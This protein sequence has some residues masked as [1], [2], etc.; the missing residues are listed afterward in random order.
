MK[1]IQNELK[2]VFPVVPTPMGIDEELDFCG[3][4]SCI[5]HYLKADVNGLTILGSG[6]ELPYLSDEEQLKILIQSSQKVAKRKPII[7]GVNTFSAQ[8]AAAK[9]LT[10][11]QYAD[12]VL[13]LFTDYYI[14]DFEDLMLAIEEVAS[15]SPLPILYYHF[16]Q[17]S[18]L[19]LKPQ[20]LV[21]ILKLDNVIGI[22]DSALNHCAAKKILKGA[23]GTHYFT[24]LGLLY[25]QL[26]EAGCVGAICPLAAISPTLAKE[27][28]ES[29]L[30][31]KRTEAKVKHK[32]LSQLLP[33]ISK[34]SAVS[35]LQMHMLS[36]IGR[37]PFQMFKKAL[38]PHAASKEAL[39]HLGLP[40]SS[41]VRSPLQ[42]LKKGDS[43]NI[44]A[45][46]KRAGLKTIAR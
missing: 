45:C 30:A 4:T 5:D 8:H 28:Y 16:P 35:E 6:G 42:S 18:G 20:Q 24:G 3:L 1:N 43:E 38:S 14:V 44:L 31:K 46:L 26:I 15:T 27:L 40:I 34:P 17:V 22:K 21:A 13:L 37:L 39:R 12:A 2:G 23:A 10:Y 11:Q 41:G 36:L 9:I 25:P 19:F 29:S 7:V 33:I 32:Q